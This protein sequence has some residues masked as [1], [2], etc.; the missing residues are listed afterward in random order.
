MSDITLPH[1]NEFE[2]KPFNKA[3]YF[4]R[5]ILEM[6]LSQK[7]KVDIELLADWMSENYDSIYL[8]NKPLKFNKNVSKK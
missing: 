1:P 6:N 2:L 3:H 7:L 4:N 8:Y 5:L